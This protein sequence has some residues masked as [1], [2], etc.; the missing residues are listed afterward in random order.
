MRRW[1]Y[2]A[3]AL[4]CAVLG[5]QT[6]GAQACTIDG[7]PT[8]TVNGYDVVL[9]KAVPTGP[10]LRLWAPFV[11][12]FPLHTGRQ[13][14]LSEIVQAVPLQAEAF[15]TPWRWNFGDGTRPARGMK[16]QHVFKKPGLYKVTVDAYFPSHKFWYTFDAVQVRVVQ[17]A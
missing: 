12:S 1:M 6:A 4:A 7:K 10:N 11:L 14:S 9:N 3:V 17:S 5:V 2:G 15:K 8:L 13:E 16:V